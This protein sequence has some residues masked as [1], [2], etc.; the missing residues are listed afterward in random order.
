ML[1][2][3]VKSFLER[4]SAVKLAWCKCLVAMALT[5]HCAA[6]SLK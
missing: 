2:Q 6:F 5:A 3:T 1:G 4:E